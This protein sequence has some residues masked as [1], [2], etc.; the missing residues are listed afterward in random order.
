MKKIFLFIL[1]LFFFASSINR[2]RESEFSIF[3]WDE[4]ITNEM[5]RESIYKNLKKLDI[6]NVY[7][8]LENVNEDKIKKFIGDLRINC[9]VDTYMLTGYPDWYR[10][11]NNINNVL[12]NLYE[13]NKK[14]SKK[15]KISGLALDVEPWSTY[16]NWDRDIYVSTM[17]T[18][19]QYA[20]SLDIKLIMVI[21][22]WLEEDDLEI[23][24]K[25]SDKIAIMNYNVNH[26]IDLINEEIKIAKKYKKEVDIIAEVQKSNEKYGVD[27]NTTYYYKGYNKLHEDWAKIKEVYKYSKINFSYHDYSNIEEFIEKRE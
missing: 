5:Y 14:V 13:Y 27:K 7:Q 22:F 2:Q 19:Y 11:H 18:S 25:N 1:I 8:N 24:V 17:Q 3:S 16:E 10:E 4:N 21:P 12:K 26:P 23:I 15:Y 9:N 20:K 6:K